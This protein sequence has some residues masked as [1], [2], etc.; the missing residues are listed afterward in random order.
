MQKTM[1]LLIMQHTK[2]IAPTFAHI[3][4]NIPPRYMQQKSAVLYVTLHESYISNAT[5]EFVIYVTIMSAKMQ[6]AHLFHCSVSYI[7]A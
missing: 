3:S 7:T 6:P 2:C 1:S 4:Q 5:N